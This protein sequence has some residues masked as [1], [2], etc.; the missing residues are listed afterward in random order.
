MQSGEQKRTDHVHK[1]KRHTYE[2]GTKVFFCA[3]PKCNKKLKVALALGKECI[4]WRCGEVFILTEYSLRLV[5][6]HCENCHKSKGGSVEDARLL[7]S[8]VVREATI[9]AAPKEESLIERMKRLAGNI[10]EDDD[11]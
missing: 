11:L 7:N 1:F 10:E 8:D 3:L 6:P 2:T 4:C 5:K 9:V